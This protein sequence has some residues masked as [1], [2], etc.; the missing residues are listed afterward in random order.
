MSRKLFGRSGSQTLFF[1]W[2]EATTRNASVFEGYA[3]T[4]YVIG[5]Y[6]CYTLGNCT[7]SYPS[8]NATSRLTFQ[9][10][11]MQGEGRSR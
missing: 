10:V 11:K 8:P 7:L 5:K 6:N 2:R 9:K 1:K 3:L 4:G